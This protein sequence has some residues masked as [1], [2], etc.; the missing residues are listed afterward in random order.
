MIV[1]HA[2]RAEQERDPTAATALILTGFKAP[3]SVEFNGEART[4]LVTR[5]IHGDLAYLV[6][7]Q[8]T[9]KSQ[10]EMEKALGELVS[11]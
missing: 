5:L 4:N 2:W 7:L 1:T 10:T 11:P 8:A 6:P 9:M 3:P